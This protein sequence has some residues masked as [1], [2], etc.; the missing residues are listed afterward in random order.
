MVL[1]VSA[2]GGCPRWQPVVVDDRSPGA[3]GEALFTLLR[4]SPHPT[5]VLVAL[6]GDEDRPARW[7]TLQLT[8]SEPDEAK[9]G[10]EVTSRSALVDRFAADHRLSRREREVIALAATGL[11][12]KEIAAEVGCT[13][14]TVAVYWSRIY[15]K[16]DCHSH[17]EVMARLLATAF[18]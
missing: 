17:G 9:S 8:M 10:A 6:P 13:P 11:S 14:P 7:C 3:V 18:R 16:L 15:R 5:T 4:Q 12:T 1:R 2:A